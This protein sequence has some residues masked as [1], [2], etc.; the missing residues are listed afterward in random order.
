VDGARELTTHI[1]T[2]VM[3]AII[4]GQFVL[5][6]RFHRRLLAELDADPRRRAMFYSMII[7]YGG[8]RIAFVLLIIFTSIDLTAV[9]VGWAWP[10]DA[11]DYALAAYLLLLIGIGALRIRR[12]MARGRVLPLRADLAP[13]IPRTA[14]ERRLAA[15]VAFTA[16]ITEEAL[17]RGLLIAAATKL[18]HLPLAAAVAVS[19]V[20]FVGGHAYQ[21][22]RG[23]LG[24]AV[25]GGL[26]TALYLI[27]GSLLLPIVVHIIQDLV[28]LLMIPAHPTTAPPAEP[29][30]AVPPDPPPP[31]AD[32]T[33][34]TV[35][36]ASPGQL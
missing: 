28:A 33:P 7:G 35:R 27:S 31:A 3:L 24:S 12:A 34:P 5:G 9:D 25:V 4:L 1:L 21:G 2:A 17:Y 10:G 8:V 36:S 32:A 29:V 14:R 16:G 23:M 15:A 22:R 19:L 20:L 26:F 30:P 6:T 11:I 13:L 18:Y